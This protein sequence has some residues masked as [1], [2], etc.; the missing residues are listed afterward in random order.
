MS[1]VSNRSAASIASVCI[2]LKQKK[3]AILLRQAILANEDMD[4]TARLW[5]QRPAQLAT[6]SRGAAPSS[7]IPDLPLIILWV[8]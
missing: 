7:G 8:R 5:N 3:L 6:D 1:L 4:G 2:G